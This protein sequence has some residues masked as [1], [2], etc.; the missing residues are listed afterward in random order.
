MLRL[1]PVTTARALR[2]G[3][4]WVC[5]DWWHCR[6]LCS[7]KTLTAERQE[8]QFLRGILCHW[9]INL[10]RLNGTSYSLL[11]EQKLHTGMHNELKINRICLL[12][13]LILFLWKIWLCWKNYDIS[14]IADLLIM[15]I[16]FSRQS[17][18]CEGEVDLNEIG[19]SFT[20]QPYVL[21]HPNIYVSFLFLI[22][23]RVGTVLT[24]VTPI[25]AAPRSNPGKFR[26]STRKYV[27]VSSFSIPPHQ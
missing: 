4:S 16:W 25:R 27:T 6:L 7:I 9:L 15:Q 13:L 2:L 17:M 14:S 11:A 26:D 5:L 10:F 24:R 21:L 3:W 20:S 19:G 18:I 1:V 12:V 22:T 23:E 8:K